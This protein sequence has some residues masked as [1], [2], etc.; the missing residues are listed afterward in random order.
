[1]TAGGPPR[2]E[3]TA[4][5]AAYGRARR[6]GLA[7]RALERDALLKAASLLE[8]ARAHPTDAAAL[9]EALRFNTELWTI[10]QADLADPANPLDDGLKADLLRL[11]VFM[12]RSAAL[13]TET[14]DNAALAAM[15]DVNLALA[16][17]GG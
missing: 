8:R 12:D 7:G 15:I 2:P 11:S 9:A 14:F 6:R 17:Q 1:M 16:G 10:F 3:P 4:A 13:L 5:Y